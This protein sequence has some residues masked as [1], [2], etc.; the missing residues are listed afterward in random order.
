MKKD[1]RKW[2]DDGVEFETIEFVPEEE[3]EGDYTKLAK[4][5]IGAK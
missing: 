5:I 1:D 3:Y 2:P 4:E